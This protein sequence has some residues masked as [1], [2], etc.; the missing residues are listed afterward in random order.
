MRRFSDSDSSGDSN[1]RDAT[2]D[3]HFSDFAIGGAS[4]ERDPQ[5]Q[6]GQTGTFRDDDD[7]VPSYMSNPAP[8]SRRDH[9]TSNHVPSSHMD[10]EIGPPGMASLFALISQFEPRESEVTVHW[11]PFIPHMVP[12]I[13]EI[14]AFIKVPRPDGEL[15]DLGLI[16]VD[17]PS[18][19]QSNPQ[20]LKMELREEFGVSS[21]AN[22][23]D[24]YIGMIEDPQKNR[25]GLESWLTSIEDIHRK[26]PPPTMMYSHRMPEME[27]LMEPFSEKFEDVLN[28]LVLP[29]CQI[30]LSFEEYAKVMCVLLDIPVRGNLVESLH[31]MFTLYCS[32]AGNTYFQSID[33]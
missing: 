16:V 2:L 17:E 22:E 24:G 15:D 6:Y 4:G 12:A 14:D 29:S 13:G 7:D 5:N 32:F 23:G 20:V 10:D 3:M 19:A 31:H 26:R 18:I 30:D 9:R 25:K 1:D 21:P 28:A 11:K 8:A 27:D 33:T